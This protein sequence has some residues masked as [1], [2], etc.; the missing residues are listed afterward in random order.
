MQLKL[1]LYYFLG[2]NPV[3]TGNFFYESA[4]MLTV[5]SVN[6]TTNSSNSKGDHRVS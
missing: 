2:L 4:G 5:L 6:E 3:G 1:T